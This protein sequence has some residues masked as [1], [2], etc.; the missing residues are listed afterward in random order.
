MEKNRIIN[1]PAYFM[2]QGTEAFA[3]WNI[4]QCG[5]YT[6]VLEKSQIEPAAHSPHDNH[7]QW[8]HSSSVTR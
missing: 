6:M 4:G 3:L 5:F 7:K 2:R 1:H 8:L